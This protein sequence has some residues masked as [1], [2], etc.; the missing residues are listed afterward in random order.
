VTAESLKDFIEGRMS[1]SH[2][3]QPVMLLTLLRSGGAAT[4]EQIAR[5][6][7]AM[8]ESQVEYYRQRV[9]DMV[10]RVLASHGVAE[11]D[12]DYWKLTVDRLSPGESAALRGLLESK[13]AEYLEENDPWAHRR[14]GQ[15]LSPSRRYEALKLSEGKCV[16]CGATSA[17]TP[18]E[19]D[20]V[21]PRSKGGGDELENLQVLCRTC[22]AGKSN[23]DDTD[24]R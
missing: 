15:A 6:I 7:L 20:H 10:G 21:V 14:P 2:V 24:F 8:D 3:Y 4:E 22:N 13:L 9:R 11:R 5:E 1:L 17:E 18:L 23:R 16:L 12:G 19:V